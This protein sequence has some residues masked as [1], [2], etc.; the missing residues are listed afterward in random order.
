M[1][2]VVTLLQFQLHLYQFHLQRLIKANLLQLAGVQ[3]MQ[4]VVRHQAHGQVVKEPVVHK[5]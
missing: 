1:M 3:P 4:Q 2:E 5:L